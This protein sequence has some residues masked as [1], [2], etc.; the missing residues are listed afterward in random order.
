MNDSNAALSDLSTKKPFMSI[1]VRASALRADRI[2]D[3]AKHT[4]DPIHLIRAFGIAPNTAMHYF[5]A[6]H[7][8]QFRPDPIAP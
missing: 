4:A 1:G 5:R 7:P 6:A 3:E 2:L 8:A